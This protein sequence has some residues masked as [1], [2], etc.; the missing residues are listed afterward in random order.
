MLLGLI[1]CMWRNIV[2]P[3]IVWQIKSLQHGGNVAA[4]VNVGANIILYNIHAQ[5][6]KRFPRGQPFNIL[7][8]KSL[9]NLA[10]GP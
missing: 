3:V 1:S 2:T 5:V 8:V 9:C 6:I 4:H 10:S 7:A